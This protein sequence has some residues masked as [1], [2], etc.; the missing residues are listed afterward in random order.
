MQG[1]A[2]PISK[3]DN[4]R[5]LTLMLFIRKIKSF[6]IKKKIAFSSLSIE[7]LEQYSG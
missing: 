3:Y 5:N 1:L 6:Y 4:L 7:H 2:S